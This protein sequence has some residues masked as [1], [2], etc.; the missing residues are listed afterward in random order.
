MNDVDVFVG[1]H[2]RK[3]AHRVNR[4]QYVSGAPNGSR[5]FTHLKGDILLCDSCTAFWLE[6]QG[7]R[8]L[9]T[10]ERAVRLRKAR[11]DDDT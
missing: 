10:L 5:C 1:C 11:I 4:K 6:R 3:A 7:A 8:D 2:G 9:A